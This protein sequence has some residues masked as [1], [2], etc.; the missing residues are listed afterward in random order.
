MLNLKKNNKNVKFNTINALTSSRKKNKHKQPTITICL[1]THNCSHCLCYHIPFDIIFCCK[2][3]AWNPHVYLQFYLKYNSDNITI[4]LNKY[5]HSI[6]MVNGKMRICLL[7]NAILWQI[8]IMR[9]I[10]NMFVK[11]LWLKK[12]KYRNFHQNNS[13]VCF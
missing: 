3:T 13:I 7:D 10:V 2:L 8:H 1:I 5:I 6:Y 4:Y 12:R 11:P 9:I